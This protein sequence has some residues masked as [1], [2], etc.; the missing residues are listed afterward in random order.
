MESWG[1]TTPNNTDDL[2]SL[3]MDNST[4]PKEG[5]S[6]LTE[7]II[8][9]MTMFVVTLLFGMLPL[10]LFSAVRDNTDVASRNRWKAVISFSSCF[11]GGVFIAACL[12]ELVPEVEKY[13]AKVMEEIQNEYN[14]DL[15]YPLA[16]LTVVMGFFLILTIEQ[17]VLH[18]QESWMAEAEGQPLLARSRHMSVSGHDYR[19]I[20]G[21]ESIV[22]LS[23]EVHHS[24][25]GH[26]DHTHMSHGVFQHSTLRSVLLLIALSFHSVFGGLV[27][28]LQ[29]SK[30][31]LISIF[32][33]IIVHKAV[34]AFSLGLNIAQS[35][36]TRRS[37]I[38]SSLCFSLASPIGVAIGIG[39]ADLPASLPSSIANGVL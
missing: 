9:M 11:G 36:M 30:S 26:E 19:P 34:M 4:E 10:K 24:Q 20:Q 15:D 6:L 28:G 37:F 14:V 27:I 1:A 31:T 7:K 23:S 38:L 29:E 5:I 16:Q 33:A 8:V 18:F 35:N 22:G 21:E 32:L 2:D 3:I 39:I 17:T 13:I 12:L 25:D